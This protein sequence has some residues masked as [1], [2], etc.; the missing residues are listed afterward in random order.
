MLQGES[1]EPTGKPIVWLVNLGGHDYSSL[2]T[3]GRIMPLTTGNVSPFGMDR[4]VV[5][6]APRL[7]MAKAEDYIAISGLQVLNAL[8]LA[9]WFQKFEKA[10]L[11]QWSNKH[12]G[13]STIYLS[14]SVLQSAMTGE[15][16]SPAD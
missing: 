11:L 7:R 14:R 15:L 9:M 2:E 1:S 4:Q 10:Q 16:L 5:L 12:G 6:I 13:Y 3:F 8:V